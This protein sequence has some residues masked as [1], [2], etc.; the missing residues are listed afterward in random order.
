MPSQTDLLTIPEAAKQ[1]LH[2]ERKLWR[3]I[4]DEELPAIKRGRDWFISQD[5]IN[6]LRIDNGKE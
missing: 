1:V 2:S 4:Q 6:K 5:E 3:M